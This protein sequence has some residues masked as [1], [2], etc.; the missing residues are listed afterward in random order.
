MRS[1]ARILLVTLPFWLGYGIL[2][3][4]L[5]LRNTLFL[6]MPESTK[7]SRPAEKYDFFSFGA[8][9]KAGFAKKDITPKKIPWLAG[10]YPPHLGL[11]V[12]DRLWVK[13]LA[14]QDK[15]GSGVAIVS[16]DLIGLLPDEIEKIK[17]LVT[18]ADP[19]SIFISATHTHSGPDTIGLWGIPP[20]SGK[21]KKY[22]EFL[23]KS[24]V[25]AIDESVANLAPGKIRFAQGEFPGYSSG[26]E[27]NPPDY[28][29]SV[30]QAFFS[31]GMPVTLVN[32][33]VHADVVKSFYV[34]ADFPYYLSE[35]LG[36]LTGGEV[37][38]IPGAIGGVQ[39][40]VDNNQDFFYVRTL[41]EALADK[42]FQILE[43]PIVPKKALIT[44]RIID[45]NFAI[46][47][48][49]FLLASKIGMIS[50]L[51]DKEN[52]MTVWLQKVVIGPAEI[53][54]VPGEL[55]PKIWWEIKPKMKGKPKFI[56]GLTNGELGYI[57]SAKDFHSG[58]HKYH[59]G[60]SVSWAFGNFVRKALN[61]LAE[62]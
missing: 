44:R 40:R 3:K 30:M 43:R 10:Y 54:A 46:R 52:R 25:E 5:P 15:N 48:Q 62:D 50:N 4:Y 23:R 34:S 49:K 20:F 16:C 1:V 35:R 22:L 59:A 41:G 18:K 47:N 56:F 33:A 2:W 13:V 57:L 61:L 38:F 55:F 29:V 26:R 53:L 58:K 9:I 11:A 7:F 45:L 36:R 37:M 24:I 19:S 32:F 17:S 51:A 6:E 27:E 39:P 21:D 42:V 12:H 60:M 14:L 8:P 31:S 28:G